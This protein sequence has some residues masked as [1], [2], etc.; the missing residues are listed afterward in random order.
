LSVPNGGQ[1]IEELFALK[2]EYANAK[3]A[4][5]EACRVSD[6]HCSDHGCW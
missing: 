4:L 1:S 3:A 6:A 2:A 5:S